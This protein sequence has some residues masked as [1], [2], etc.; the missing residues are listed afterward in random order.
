MSD[1]PPAEVLA[2]LCDRDE[3]RQLAERYALAVDSRD[4]DTLAQLFDDDF[5]RWG[6]GPQAA[7]AYFD[8]TLRAHV[9]S[10]HLVANHIIDFDDDHRARGVVYCRAH[11]HYLEPDHWADLAF[12]YFDVYVKRGGTWRIAARELKAWYRQL[13]GHPDHGMERRPL[14]SPHGPLDGVQLPEAFPTWAA[15]WDRDPAE[16]PT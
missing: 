11:H 10:M 9:A 14:T 12:V 6:K 15:F 1:M 5:E 13:I 4:I 2:R 16:K 7:W 8:N 3:I